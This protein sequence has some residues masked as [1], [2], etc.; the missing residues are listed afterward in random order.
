MTAVRR[1]SAAAY[2]VLY[3][4]AVAAA[5]LELPALTAAASA[6][7]AVFLVLE[8]ARVPRSQ[9]ALAGLLAAIGLAL[10]AMAGQ[11][12]RTL[13][14][15]LE[16]TLP[17]MVLF[18]AVAF[19]NRPALA[20]P[21]FRKVGESMVRQPPGRRFLMVS[22]AGSAIGAVLNL[23]GLYLVL[24]LL[25]RQ[26]DPRLERRLTMAAMRGF[27]AAAS[28]SPF[29]VAM[30]VVLVVLPDLRWPQVAPAGISVAFVLLAVAYGLDRLTRRPRPAKRAAPPRIPGPALA[31]T[32]LV[33]ALLALP[34]LLLSELGDIGI[35]FAIGAVAPVVAL[36]WQAVLAGRR[37]AGAEGWT[38]LREHA[39]RLPAL[40][41]EG[42]VFTGANLLGA[43]VA[44]ALDPAQVS[45]VLAALSLGPDLG[46]VLLLSALTL[47]G[48]V[49]VHP[50]VLV[51]VAGQVVAPE[52]L[53]VPAWLMGAT[54]L[55][56]W[57]LGTAMSPFSG[58]VM[59]VARFLKRSPWQVAW[60]W[61]APYVLI[62]LVFVCALLV[63]LQHVAA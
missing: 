29:F 21:S 39:A 52:A 59:Q 14:L 12:G 57:S 54:L 23:A 19:L 4:G 18:A 9:L 7:L 1:L 37:G 47:L 48:A 31:G 8:A 53:G 61:N 42:F 63:L 55:A 28:W 22:L 49:G 51:V 2:G 32:L 5:L 56:G 3:V 45:Q 60:R 62:A 38:L 6:G 25:G 26:D 50:V 17:L 58:T 33:F 36:G 11:G 15:G 40:R 43:G 13:T 35:P 24:S 16:R 41:G 20:S 44:A 27:S 46:L 34:V 10:G 30:A